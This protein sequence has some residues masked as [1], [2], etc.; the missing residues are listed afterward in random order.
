MLSSGITSMCTI[1][2]LIFSARLVIE[3]ENYSTKARIWK[4]FL[5]C[6]IPKQLLVSEDIFEIYFNFFLFFCFSEVSPTC[7]KFLCGSL[8]FHTGFK[9]EKYPKSCSKLSGREA[10]SCGICL[11][12]FSLIN[13]KFPMEVSHA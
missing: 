7:S 6:S 4:S 2:I 10:P 11:H 5:F 13:T 8:Y 1:K 9:R 12:N 3:W